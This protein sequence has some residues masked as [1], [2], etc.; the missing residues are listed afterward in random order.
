V[1]SSVARITLKVDRPLGRRSTGIVAGRF[2]RET[3]GICSSL[4]FTA[5]ANAHTNLVSL[6]R[7]SAQAKIAAICSPL[8]TEMGTG[9]TLERASSLVISRC[10]AV[11]DS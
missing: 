8:I 11:R 3:D 5:G 4:G 10:N 7:A 2:L 9:T 1:D 6:Y